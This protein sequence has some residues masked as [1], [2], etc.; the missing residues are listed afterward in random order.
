MCFQVGQPF[1]PLWRARV[2]RPFF[3]PAS[4]PD[5]DLGRCGG[6]HRVAA[7]EPEVVGVTHP[8]RTGRRRRADIG[9]HHRP[10]PATT[11]AQ[12]PPLPRPDRRAQPH[13]PAHRRPQ[14]RAHDP[15][16]CE[17]G[18]AP[19]TEPTTSPRSCSAPA[20]NASAPTHPATTA[21]SNATTGSWP[22]NSST[23]AN[24]PVNTSA[25]APWPSGTFTTTTIDHIRPPETGHQPAASAPASPTSRP[26]TARA[27]PIRN[28]RAPHPVRQCSSV[29]RAQTPC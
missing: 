16:R 24:G 11:G 10:P 8:D 6:P 12:P 20:I 17:E 4:Q 21:K 2:G 18:R 22:R 28:G 26:H 9:A 29:I 14:A 23:P 5:R 27:G 19:A 25:A 13:C 3:G 1:P 15:R 7:P